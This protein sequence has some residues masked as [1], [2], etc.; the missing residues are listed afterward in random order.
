MAGTWVDLVEVGPRDGLQ[1]EPRV[2]PTA[3]KVAMVNALGA[4]GLREIEVSA[5]VSPRWVPQLADAD[6]VFAAIQRAPGTCY[7]ALVP[8][9]HGLD[10]ALAAGVGRASVFT[11]ASDTFNRRNVNTNTEGTFSRIGR[12]LGRCQALGLP[13]RGYVSCS[14]WCPYEGPVA[15]EQACL[16][17]RRL[18]DLG[19]EEVSMGDT[20]GK[21]TAVEVERLLT[22][23]F[24]YVPPARVALHLHDTFGQARANVVAAWRLGVRCFDA[25]V[26]G[27]GGCP[28]APGAAGNVATE[29]VV[30]A[31]R[32]AGAQVRCD[33]AAL[34]AARAVLVPTLGPLGVGS[35]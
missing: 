24:A 4:A 6:Q 16:V 22:A 18:L 27:L 28:Y 32:D 1:N 34:A 20:I 25:S 11:A 2:V 26:G 8:N 7:S 31:L 29:A 17:A 14:F 30:E 13:S 33:P 15:V 35:S 19:A 10:R 12:V 3:V 5:F 23:L 9:E 21:A